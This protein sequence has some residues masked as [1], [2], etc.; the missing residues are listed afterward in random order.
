M[1]SCLDGLYDIS[2]TPN[3]GGDDGLHNDLPTVIQAL[4]DAKGWSLRQT[5]YKAGVSP[6]TLSGIINGTTPNP[7]RDTLEGL[8]QAF[9]LASADIFFNLG[10][11]QI[12]QEANKGGAA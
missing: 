7:R 9:N 10:V 11:R 12:V 6:S 5:A 2:Y 3:Q 1:A 4:M 8:A